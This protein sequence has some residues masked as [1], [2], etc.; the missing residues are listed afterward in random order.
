MGYSNRVAPSA[1][2]RTAISVMFVNVMSERGLLSTVHVIVTES[3]S[4]ITASLGDVWID[5]TSVIIK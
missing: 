4:R 2:S 5:G 3:P 1:V